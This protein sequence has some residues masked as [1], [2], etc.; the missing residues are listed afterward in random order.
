ME[1]G[2]SNRSSPHSTSTQLPPTRMSMTWGSPVGFSQISAPMDYYMGG[3][4]TGG[5]LS[6]LSIPIS[7]TEDAIALISANKILR[8]TLPQISSF[9]LPI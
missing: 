1:P 7:R 8:L 3:R 4:R 5:P 2:R 9:H 6:Y